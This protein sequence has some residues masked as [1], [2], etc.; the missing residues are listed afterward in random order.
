MGE[1]NSTK[2]VCDG[3]SQARMVKYLDMIE[4][5]GNMLKKPFQDVTKGDVFE[6]VRRIQAADYSNIPQ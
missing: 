4:R 5:I 6:F 3:Y 2:I 1:S